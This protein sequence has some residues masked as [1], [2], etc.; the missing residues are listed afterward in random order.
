MCLA[1][2]WPLVFLD[3]PHHLLDRF[4]SPQDGDFG[5]SSGGYQGR[6]GNETW[7]AYLRRSCFTAVLVL[8][9]VVLV[10]MEV[11]A[12]VPTMGHCCDSNGGGRGS[13]GHSSGCGGG[14]S[15][16]GG[17]RSNGALQRC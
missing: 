15:H 16:S 9:V 11:A 7:I 13:G 5:F 4:W 3:S 1:K 8:V 17:G 14:G 10:V 2:I 12:V 6:G